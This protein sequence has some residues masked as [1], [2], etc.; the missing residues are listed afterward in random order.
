M[1]DPD[2]A[3]LLDDPAR[4]LRHDRAGLR[5]RLDALPEE[6]GGV[7]REVFTQAEAVFGSAPATPAEFASWLHFAATVLGHRE[8]AERVAAAEPLLPWRTVW[9]WWRPVGAHEAAPNL[10]GDRS[11]EAYEAGASPP[12]GLGPVVRGR[13]VRPGHRLPRPAP[14][15][16]TAEPYEE[17]EPDGPWLFDGDEESWA[18]RHPDSWEEPIPLDGG[19]YVFLD[20]RGVAVVE[21]NDAA[22][23]HWPTGGA[24]SSGPAP[25]DGGPWFRPG[26]RT[27]DGP[28]TAAR[29]DGSSAL[30]GPPRPGRRPARRPHPRTDP[31]AARR[32]RTAPPL[33]GRRHVLR[34][35]RRAPDPGPRGLLRVGAFDLGYRDPG[36]SSS[37]PR[38]APSEC[39]GRTAATATAATPSSRSSATWSP[40]SGSWRASAATWAPAGTRT[41]GG[42]REGLPPRDGDRRRRGPRRGTPGAEVW[43]HLFASVTELG[44][45]GY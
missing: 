41:R 44:V 20:A 33:G 43:E 34:A 35:R 45:D 8:Y 5:A 10:S 32:G 17:T 9:A 11:A 22:L 40:S 26:T 42:G 27:A 12:E 21:R 30:R 6:H 29:L 36:R 18:L 31:D 19:R 39:A 28:L 16:G 14:A 3:A 4:V 2:L 24:D 15:E 25:A 13:L 1:T 7:G 38:P 23:A 37:T